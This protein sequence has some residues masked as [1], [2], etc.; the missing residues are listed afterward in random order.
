MSRLLAGGTG[1]GHHGRMA[2]DQQ[3]AGAADPTPQT[4][5]VEFGED[6]GEARPAAEELV[7]L[8]GELGVAHQ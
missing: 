7:Q 4:S 2:T 5:V 6:A 1:R 8:G 3:P